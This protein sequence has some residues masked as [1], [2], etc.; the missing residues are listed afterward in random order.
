[1]LIEFIKYCQKEKLFKPVDKI[2]LAVSGG[3]DSV[4]MCELFYLAGYKFGIAH[5][6]FKLRGKESDEDEKFVRD[7]ANKYKAKFYLKTF[8]TN[9]YAVSN[10]IS[11]QMAARELRY[12]WFE[13]LLKSENYK[14]VAAAHHSDDQI[15]T[16]FINILRGTG[17][18]GLHGILPKQNN[19]IHPLLFSNRKRI[20]DF[21]KK[22]NLKF[23]EDSSNKSE[24]YL[25]NKIRHS[26]IPLLKDINPEFEQIINKNIERFRETEKIYAGHIEREKNKIIEIQ[27]DKIVFPIKKLKKSDSLSTYLYEFLYP[28]NFSFNVIE[29]IVAAL[30]DISG[31]QFFSPTHRLIK[32]REELIITP[33][34]HQDH[35]V[36]QYIVNEESIDEPINLKIDKVFS[37]RDFKIPQSNNIACLDHEKLKFPLIL[38]KWKEGDYF[39]PL[40]LNSR[41]K[42][43]D[44]FID[45]KFSLLDKENAWL[46]CSGNKIVWIVGFRIDN[47]FKITKRTKKIFQIEYFPATD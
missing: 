17:I 20:E 38:K 45:R 26:I 24:K 42:L 44:F 23:R 43:S 33:Q 11:I 36:E 34:K 31:K 25:R 37:V 27:E 22:N 35:S 6:N 8:E 32:D 9:K 47:R 18:A 19:I 12:I 21:R 2:L 13:E 46:L 30:D 41:K 15:E 5:C 7:L 10:G 29:D 16:F 40:G 4:V 39:Y 1:M 28:Y 14:Y 3:V